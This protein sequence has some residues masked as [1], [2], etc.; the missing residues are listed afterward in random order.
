[1]SLRNI[2]SEC[3]EDIATI[4]LIRDEQKENVEEL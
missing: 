1:M 4:K 3:R 2:Q